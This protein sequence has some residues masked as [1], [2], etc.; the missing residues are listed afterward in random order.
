MP[1]KVAMAPGHKTIQTDTDYPVSPSCSIGECLNAHG[2]ATSGLNLLT[3]PEVQMSDT[4]LRE[5]TSVNRRAGTPT[6]R[7][8]CAVSKTIHTAKY[9]PALQSS[10]QR[11]GGH[12]RVLCANHAIAIVQEVAERQAL[13]AFSRCRSPCSGRRGRWFKSSRP[14]YPL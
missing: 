4:P 14:D 10:L 9:D 6:P 7:S 3:A 5:T 8:Q 13:T 2:D 1:G 12:C 11:T